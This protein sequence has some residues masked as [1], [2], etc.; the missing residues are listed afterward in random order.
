LKGTAQF[1]P[2]RPVPIPK[3]E[4]NE[5]SAKI[6]VFF[7]FKEIKKQTANSQGARAPVPSFPTVIIFN[8][9]AMIFH[10]P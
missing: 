10:V 1:L 6:P 2:D 5:K 9:K 3:E 8:E 4:N 7:F